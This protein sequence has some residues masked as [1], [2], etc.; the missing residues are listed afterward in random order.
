MK[1]IEVKMRELGVSSHPD[2]KL[3][4]FLDHK[5]MV[6]VKTERRGKPATLYMS[7]LQEQLLVMTV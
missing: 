2:Y 1:W 7:F 3:T 4:C 6:T 5:A